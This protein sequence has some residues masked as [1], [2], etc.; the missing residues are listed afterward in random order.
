MWAAV[1]VG[2]DGGGGGGSTMDCK[3]PQHE[4]RNLLWKIELKE[5]V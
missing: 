3:P 4:K 2:G 1:G 5:A